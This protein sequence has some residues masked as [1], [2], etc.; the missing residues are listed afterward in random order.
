MLL[1]APRDWG[2]GYGDDP[3]V[4]WIYECTICGYAIELPELVV[5]RAVPFCEYRRHGRLELVEWEWD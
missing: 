1:Q 3:E 5:G 2:G 4:V